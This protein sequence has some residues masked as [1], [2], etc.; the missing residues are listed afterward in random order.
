MKWNMYG[1]MLLSSIGAIGG[2]LYFIFF[3][4]DNSFGT[5]FWLFAWVVLYLPLMGIT[6]KELRKPLH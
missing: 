5:L 6:R 2:C 3:T 1:S 4:D